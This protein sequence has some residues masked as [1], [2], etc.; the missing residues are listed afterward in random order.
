M[1]SGLREV[2][3]IGPSSQIHIFRVQFEKMLLRISP[4][5]NSKGG[6]FALSFGRVARFQ[7]RTRF[8]KATFLNILIASN[9]HLID[10][11]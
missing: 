7:N 1:Y 8:G 9:K 3:A 4:N 6:P 11:F 2:Q 10:A 5:S